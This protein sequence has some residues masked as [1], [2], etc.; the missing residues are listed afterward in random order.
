[1]INL[2]TIKE[3]NQLVAMEHVGYLCMGGV[4]VVTSIDNKKTAPVG[5]CPLGRPWC[6]AHDANQPI[7]GRIEEVIEPDF[8]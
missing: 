1:M 3:C 7:I 2:I 4:D 6:T 8:L 5:E